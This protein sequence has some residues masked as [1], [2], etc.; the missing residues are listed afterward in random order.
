MTLNP[1]ERIRYAAGTGMRKRVLILFICAAAAGCASSHSAV[2]HPTPA[3]LGSYPYS[4]A[5]VD[6]MSGMIPHHAQA[7]IMPPK[8][9]RAHRRTPL[10][11]SYRIPPSSWKKK[12]NNEHVVH[13]RPLDSALLIRTVRYDDANNTP[14]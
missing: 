3:G 4:D 13:N 8:I 11:R 7:G 9:G 10:P 12:K 6:F 14:R 1:E 5:D 2:I